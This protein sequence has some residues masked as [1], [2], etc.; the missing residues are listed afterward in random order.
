MHD[1]QV[2]FAA[3]EKY[4]LSYLV[5]GTQGV[6]PTHLNQKG[7]SV[8]WCGAE[9]TCSVLLSLGLRCGYA[10]SRGELVTLARVR[11][12]S[13]CYY[14]E[15]EKKLHH[16]ANSNPAHK[17][18]QSVTHLYECLGCSHTLKPA[19]H[20]GP[21]HHHVLPPP[22]SNPRQQKNHAYPACT[23]QPPDLG[24]SLK[25]KGKGPH[26]AKGSM[27]LKWPRIIA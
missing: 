20:T 6:S 26:S 11:V 12:R 14:H 17:N 10:P 21:Q 19:A 23:P 1:V 25:P 7:A 3:R 2:S 8:R 16:G 15:V 18:C 27:G 24:E 5:L 22:G 4:F 13:L 9:M